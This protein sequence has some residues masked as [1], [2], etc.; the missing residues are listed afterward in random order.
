MVDMRL[1][2]VTLTL[3]R[4]LDTEP[5]AAF[6][7]QALSPYAKAGKVEAG[8]RR[9]LDVERERALEALPAITDVNH[10]SDSAAWLTWLT[11]NLSTLGTQVEPRGWA[12]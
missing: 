1:P 2:A 10:G 9:F 4:L 3:V 8:V 11:A 6:C 12:S 5:L 7:T